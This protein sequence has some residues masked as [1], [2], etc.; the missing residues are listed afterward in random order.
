M[1]PRYIAAADGI[2]S[3]LSITN[4]NAC[5]AVYVDVKS[6]RNTIAIDI[7]SF[8]LLSALMIVFFGAD[9]S[10]RSKNIKS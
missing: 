8:S 7:A 10:A 6:C 1:R 4:S 2:Q 9:D 5:I 3:I